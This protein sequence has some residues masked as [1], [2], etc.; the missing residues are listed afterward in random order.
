MTPHVQ[1]CMQQPGRLIMRGMLSCP[2]LSCSA[3]FALSHSP[4]VYPFHLVPRHFSALLWWC[5]DVKKLLTHSP[6][7]DRICQVNPAWLL[8]FVKIS[9]FFRCCSFSQFLTLFA[10]MCVCRQWRS[11]HAHTSCSWR[12]TLFTTTSTC[13]TENVLRRS[14]HTVLNSGSSK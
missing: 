9:W 7:H 4:N 1:L 6:G 14:R 13:C 3:L 5:A 11:V 2:A 10:T 8:P 12:T